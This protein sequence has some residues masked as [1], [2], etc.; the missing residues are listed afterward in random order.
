MNPNS[1]FVFIPTEQ[2]ESIQKT[3]IDINR[4]LDL[5]Q[6]G[7]T[8]PSFEDDV[9]TTKEAMSLLKISHLDTFKSFLSR[10]KITTIDE[11]GPKRYR[12][13]E[14]LRLSRSQN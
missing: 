9:L 14:I 5:I 10:N 6:P 1:S 7:N 13:S 12:K 11:G 4:K 3:L 2:W 8:A